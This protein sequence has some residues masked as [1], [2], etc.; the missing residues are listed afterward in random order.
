M[1]PISVSGLGTRDAAL[2]LLLAP[3]GLALVAG[4]VVP[5][6]A[7][8]CRRTEGARLRTAWRGSVRR[9]TPVVLALCALLFL[10]FSA[11]GMRLRSQWAKE[12]MAPGVTEMSQAI[13]AVGDKWA[14]PTMPAD[15]WRAEY[16]PEQAT[17]QGR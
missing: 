5:L 13:A 1:I 17:P 3:F 7:A 10:G 9:I 2:I 15:A 14:N 8:A 16:P 4:I 6:I 12:Q 11:A